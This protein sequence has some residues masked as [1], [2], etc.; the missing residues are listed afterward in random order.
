VSYHDFLPFGKEIAPAF[1]YNTK[2]F[3]GHERDQ[4]TGL[5]YMSARYYSSSLARFLSKDPRPGPLRFTFPQAW[6]AYLYALNNPLKFLDPDGNDIVLA[7]GSSQGFTNRMTKAFAQASRNAETGS[8]FQNAENSSITVV[9]K[10]GRLP[11]Q[12]TETGH[13]IGIGKTETTKTDT[14]GNPTEITVTI[15]T[16]N[17]S[18]TWH[19]GDQSEV[20]TDVEAVAHEFDHVNNQLT[21]EGRAETNADPNAEEQ[22]AKETGE[23]TAEDPATQKK[24]TE[25]E[26]QKAGEMLKPGQP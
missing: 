26:K 5:D 2:M 21:P 19:T 3:T 9:V 13:S 14:S 23:E 25:E 15:D 7:E 16:T 18:N 20:V 4:E 11:V 24:P 17:I 12:K 22:E 6:N 1:D 10:E 8:N